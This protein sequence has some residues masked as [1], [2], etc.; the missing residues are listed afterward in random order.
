MAAL[1]NSK[2]NFPEAIRELGYETGNGTA[3][4]RGWF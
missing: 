4:G 2:S 3:S 1:E